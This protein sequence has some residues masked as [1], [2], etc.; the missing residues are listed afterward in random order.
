MT[1]RLH[2]AF[3]LLLSCIDFTAT[4]L[5]VNAGLTTEANPLI[6][7]FAAY[8]P[9]FWLGLAVYKFALV[10]AVLALVIGIQRMSVPASTKVLVFANSIMLGVTGMHAAAFGLGI[11]LIG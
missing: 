5:L 7:R 11:G 3:Y 1:P 4:A 9:E 6:N 2:I 10:G 8:F